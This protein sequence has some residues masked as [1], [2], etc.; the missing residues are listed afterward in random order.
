MKQEFIA[1]MLEAKRCEAQAFLCLVP[2]TLRPHLEVI[3]REATALAEECIVHHF[4]AAK[5]DYKEK[6]EEKKVRKVDLE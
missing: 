2:D 3:V 4:T 1:K 5:K 6:P